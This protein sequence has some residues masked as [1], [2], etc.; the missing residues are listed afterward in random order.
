MTKSKSVS[1]KLPPKLSSAAVRL[2]ELIARDLARQ[3]VEAQTVNPVILALYAR[4]ST[5]KQRDAS[6]DDQFRECGA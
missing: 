2:V 6:I 3:D 4:Y 5:E 1:S